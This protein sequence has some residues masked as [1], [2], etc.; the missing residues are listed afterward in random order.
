MPLYH[1]HKCYVGVG[2]NN[3]GQ[4]SSRT[5]AKQISGQLRLELIASIRSSIAVADT[6]WADL[7]LV[8]WEGA[9]YM[10]IVCINLISMDS[11]I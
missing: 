9:Y 8:L 11:E 3:Y 7:A 2:S 4:N 10:H 5:C 1:I 6:F